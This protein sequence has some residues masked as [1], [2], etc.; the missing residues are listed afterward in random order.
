MF[1]HALAWNV[2][3][4]LHVNFVQPSQEASLLKAY[5]CHLDPGE[6]ISLGANFGRIKFARKSQLKLVTTTSALWKPA[7]EEP[8]SYG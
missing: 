8:G 6:N 3:L 2:S 5:S 4:R 1:F 7:Q